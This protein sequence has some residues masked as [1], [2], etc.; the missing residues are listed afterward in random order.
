MERAVRVG[1]A[2][3]EIVHTA[4]RRAGGAGETA[5][6][7]DRQPSGSVH[8]AERERAGARGVAGQRGGVR[9][10]DGRIGLVERRAAELRRR[11]A[12]DGRDLRVGERGADEAE[13]IEAPAEERVGGETTLAEVIKFRPDIDRVDGHRD[14]RR[15]GRAVDEHLPCAAA[16]GDGDMRPDAD[17]QRGGVEPLLAAAIEHREAQRVVAGLRREEQVVGRVIAEVEDALPVAAAAPKYPAGEAP[18]RAVR[19]ARR[20]L[21]VIRRAVERDGLAEFACGES[22]SADAH[23]VLPVVR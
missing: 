4:V 11:R 12:V 21:E 15:H 14:V 22:R 1:D 3:E 20:K 10:T 16:D 5:I 23:R 7:A 6:R 17:G 13:V 19:E 8:L 2:H 18:V 9:L